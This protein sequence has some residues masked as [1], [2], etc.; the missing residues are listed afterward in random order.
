MQVCVCSRVGCDHLGEEESMKV[1]VFIPLSFTQFGPSLSHAGT[2]SG[3]RQTYQPIFLHT[4]RGLSFC[5]GF[6]LCSYIEVWLSGSL[7][8]TQ[9]VVC[10]FC[11]LELF[12]DGSVI[13]TLEPPGCL[14][15]VPQAARVFCYIKC[16]CCFSTQ[17]TGFSDQFVVLDMDSCSVPVKVSTK[18]CGIR[19]EL[20]HGLKR[21]CRVPQTDGAI[22]TVC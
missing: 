3:G 13:S 22:N 1:S 15:E 5:A 11:Y 7:E 16:G 20:V 19:C 10:L 8:L 21:Y 2:C 12:S 6:R 14:G 4:D 17:V 9:G 18:R